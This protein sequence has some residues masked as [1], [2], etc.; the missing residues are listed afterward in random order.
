MELPR[1]LSVST[2]LPPH[3]A[4]QSKIKKFVQ[5][6]F[7]TAYPDMKRLIK[8]FENVQ[9][10][11]RY[12]SVPLQWFKQPHSFAE[13]N[14]KY[15]EVACD[16]GEEAIRECFK[17]KSSPPIEQMQHF[18]FVSSTGISTPTIDARLMNRL[19]IPK[20]VKR[21]P[22]WGLGC[23]GGVAGLSRAYDFVRAQKNGSALLLAVELCSLTYQDQDLS[24]S[25]LIATSLFGDGAAAAIVGY[26]K[27]GSQKKSPLILGTSTVLWQR[28]LDVMGWELVDTGLH[29][30]FSKEIPGIVRDWLKECI[31]KFLSSFDLKPAE[32]AHFVTHPGG[33]KVL[34]ALKE[35]LHLKESQLKYPRKILKNYGNISSCS[36]LFVL[37]ELMESGA[38]RSGDYGLISALGPGFSAELIL[39]RWD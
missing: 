35:S 4:P 19:E 24:K 14:A 33:A 17:R 13:R 10:S 6:H 28:S 9:V 25:N 36:V 12:L 30:I 1:I 18:L 38:A 22:I 32:I 23:L 39:L 11:S 34:D 21:T 15:V 7:Q 3:A 16:L 2:A 20:N 5:K 29:V 27:K 8:V 37:K 26:D 31:E